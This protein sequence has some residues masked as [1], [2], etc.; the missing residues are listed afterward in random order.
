MKFQKYLI[1]NLWVCVT[2]SPRCLPNDENHGSPLEIHTGPFNFNF[3]LK[4]IST[5]ISM[6]YYIY[7]I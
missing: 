6:L 2:D 5:H 7:N 4:M 1:F 3:H